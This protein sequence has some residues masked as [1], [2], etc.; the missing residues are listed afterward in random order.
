MVE[1]IAK[2]IYRIEVPLPNNPLRSLN[3]YFLRGEERDL[4]IDTGFRRPVCQA[5]L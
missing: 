5:A 4:L 3:S 2:D 1:Q